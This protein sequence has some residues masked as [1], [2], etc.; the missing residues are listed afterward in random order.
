MTRRKV[1]VVDDE[2]EANSTLCRYLE[3]R[4]FQTQPAYDGQEA[5]GQLGTFQPDL[6]LLDVL[7]PK[8]DGFTFLERLRQDPE[9]SKIQVIILTIKS[10]PKDV[11]RG[12]ALNV[13]FY[14]P[15]PFTVDNLMQFVELIV[16]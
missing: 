15:K 12:L 6:I 2:R 8:V 9:R 5:W 3:G 14:L 11:E 16:S 13:D 10:A 4:G 1:L 7:M